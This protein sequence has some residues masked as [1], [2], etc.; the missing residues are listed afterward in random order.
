MK[1]K[2]IFDLDAYVTTLDT[3]VLD[4]HESDRE[5]YKG[6]FEVITKESIF[7]PKG[8]GQN[9][10][11]GT[12]NGIN[13]KDVLTIDGELIHFVEGEIKAGEKASL[14]K[15]MPIVPSAKMYEY[16]LRFLHTKKL[17]R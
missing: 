11:K 3:I 16:T 15:R 12:I 5:E 9:A 17:S 14:L 8:G 2:K 1:T 10:D 4:S 13:V 6:C 7:S